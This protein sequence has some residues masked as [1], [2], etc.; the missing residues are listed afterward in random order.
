MPEY[1]IAVTSVAIVGGLILGVI[2]FT[3]NSIMS[4]IKE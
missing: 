2:Y 3:Y 4:N 1:V